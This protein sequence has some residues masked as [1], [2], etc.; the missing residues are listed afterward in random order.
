MTRR[1]CAKI[2]KIWQTALGVRIYWHV[3]M[4]DNNR[5]KL[6]TRDLFWFLRHWPSSTWSVMKL[7]VF[8]ILSTRIRS[9]WLMWRMDFCQV[10]DCDNWANICTS[11]MKIQPSYTFPFM[12]LVW[13]IC[14]NWSS[15][16][17]KEAVFWIVRDRYKIQHF[18]FHISYL[19]IFYANKK[20]TSL[21]IM[22]DS[23]IV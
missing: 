7:Y 16:P 13:E 22:L 15:Y 19:D 11:T 6:A 2:I 21:Q 5:I 12:H 23:K 9:A 10:W 18:L 14:R 3:L 20:R 1:S 8:D 17:I 4:F